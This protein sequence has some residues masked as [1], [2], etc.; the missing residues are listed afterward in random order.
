MTDSEGMAELKLHPLISKPAP[1][2]NATSQP[3]GGGLMDGFM[4]IEVSLL[5]E[6]FHRLLM[7]SSAAGGL[8]DTCS[9]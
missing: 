2:Y 3:S 9:R 5:S 6:N 7:G 1:G 8:I 4:I